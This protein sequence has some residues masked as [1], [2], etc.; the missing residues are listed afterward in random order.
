MGGSS[1]R[2]LDLS[3]VIIDN[4]LTSLMKGQ[5][6]W[7]MLKP[8]EIVVVLGF[9]YSD[10]EN[11]RIAADALVDR[12]IEILHREYRVRIYTGIGM[13][14]DRLIDVHQSY[15]TSIQAL[16]IAIGQNEHKSWYQDLEHQQ[17]HHWFPLQTESR[18]M[19]YCRAGNFQEVER[20][21]DEVYMQNVGKH[22]FCEETAH[23]LIQAIVYSVYRFIDGDEGMD[24][25]SGMLPKPEEIRL[26]PLD[27]LF[28]Q[29]KGAFSEIC[30]RSEMR[31]RSH[32]QRLI[33]EII[34]YI[35]EDFA[36]ASLS[37]A[38]LSSEFHLSE[39]YFSQFFKEQTG[40]LFST[41]LEGKRI[42]EACSILENRNG[43]TIEHIAHT[44]G[45]TN[46]RSFRRAFKRLTGLSP[47]EYY[48]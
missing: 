43:Y 21:I 32:N 16:S 37:V 48:A 5:A 36:N 47:S 17:F 2:E 42:R 18:L 3:R 14:V 27:S 10:P 46:T 11:N 35:G 4:A 24:K 25:I 38:K 44:V 13:F 8:H 26:E 19:N 20:I 40:T 15:N 23:N 30:S 9:I 41:Y 1:V 34:E 6:Q 7:L 39:S 29:L 45:Y 28:S 12:L 22:A 31:K 33:E